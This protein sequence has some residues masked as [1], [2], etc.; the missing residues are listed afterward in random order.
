MFCFR[1]IDLRGV[2]LMNGEE[3]F[4]FSS[5]SQCLLVWLELGL[6]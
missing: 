5:H 6:G 1:V 2:G 3:V 4:N